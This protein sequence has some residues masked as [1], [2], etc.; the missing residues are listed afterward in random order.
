LI[1]R[2]GIFLG[3]VL[4]GVLLLLSGSV[5][6]GVLAGIGL[7]AGL[8]A[9]VLLRDDGPAW[10]LALLLPVAVLTNFADVTLSSL[11]LLE[12]PR[13]VY[14]LLLCLALGTRHVLLGR[15]VRVPDHAKPFLVFLG[16]LLLTVPFSQNP[17]KSLGFF[18]KTFLMAGA[19]FV[20]SLDIFESPKGRR[21]FER[22][23]VLLVV[24]VFLFGLYQFSTQSLGLGEELRSRATLEELRSFQILR[25]PSFFAT[26]YV[27]SEFYCLLIPFFL[28]KSEGEA[29]PRKRALW[30]GSIALLVFGVLLTQQRSGI[31]IVLFQVL[32]FKVLERPGHSFKRFLKAGLAV[33]AIGLL[34]V[35]ILSWTEFGQGLFERMQATFT[36][37]SL[38]NVQDAGSTL[39]RLQRM[40]IAWLIFQDHILTGV[41]LGLSPLIYPGYGWN[42]LQFDGGAHN[43][44]LYLL[45]ESGIVGLAGF[46]Y[47]FWRYLQGFATRLKSAA[48]DDRK[49]WA[50]SIVFALSLLLDGLFSGLWSYPSLIFTTLGFAYI[51]ARAR[52][53]AAVEAR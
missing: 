33:M 32:L 4:L 22:S 19:L 30:R 1:K 40:F 6:A 14:L 39:V 3:A 35:L 51:Q 44:F 9:L 13:S 38:T 11:P 43:V 53:D 50:G 24:L 17:Y 47:C 36:A 34:A 29:G 48:G 31:A 27:T 28:V 23:L 26:T 12:T 49:F 2:I 42:W 25:V 52:T 45:S 37:D 46:L 41:G 5:D 18:V 7:A 20:L 21:I 15:P 10:G 8:F 16:I